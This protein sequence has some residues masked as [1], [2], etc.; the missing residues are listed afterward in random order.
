[1]IAGIMASGDTESLYGALITPP[2]RIVR[3]GCWKFGHTLALD[4]EIKRA[5][6]AVGRWGMLLR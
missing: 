1:M 5:A 2:K 6:S 4:E 3:L